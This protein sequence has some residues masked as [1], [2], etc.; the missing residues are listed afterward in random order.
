MLTAVRSVGAE[1]TGGRKASK[2]IPRRER[3]RMKRMAASDQRCR[4]LSRLPAGARRYASK[5]ERQRKSGMQLGWTVGCLEGRGGRWS[6]ADAGPRRGVLLTRTDG[7]GR[8]GRA[9]NP[10]GT[11]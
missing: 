1:P 5:R 3:C 11:G 10:A 2:R 9:D 4:G 8:R 6:A 7:V